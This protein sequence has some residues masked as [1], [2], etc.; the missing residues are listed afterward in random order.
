MITEKKKIS[1]IA[2]EIWENCLTEEEK[3][4]NNSNVM[5]KKLNAMLIECGDLME[6]AY[7][8]Q[9][10]KQGLA[11]GIEGELIVR[12]DLSRFWLPMYTE[13]GYQHVLSLFEEHRDDIVE[14]AVTIETEETTPAPIVYRYSRRIWREMKEKYRDFQIIA[15]EE[16][17][18]YWVFDEDAEL[19]AR[20][21]RLQVNAA[22]VIPRPFQRIPKYVNA[23]LADELVSFVATDAHRDSG[24]APYMKEAA[25]YLRKKYD[26][27]YVRAILYD[28][29]EKVIYDEEGIE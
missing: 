17:N 20:L 23:L 15:M 11:N 2:K 24:R 28:N 8:K 16:E 29:A 1:E 26:P 14:A 5:T 25:S 3:R 6:G 21:F 13:K 27:S 7:G 18:R 22:S 4:N 19:L 10:T 9:E 12:E